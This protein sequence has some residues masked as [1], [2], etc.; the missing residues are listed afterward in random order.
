MIKALALSVLALAACHNAAAQKADDPCVDVFT[1]AKA[2]TSTY[3]PALV[4][5]R[6][7]HDYPAGIADAV[8]QDRD[9][10]IAQA[11]KEWETDSQPDHVAQACSSLPVSADDAEAAR[12][13]LAKS[14]CGEFTA[15][16]MPIFEKHF[17]K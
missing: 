2:C 8:K 14:D 11:M 3:I 4:D 7:R 9:G 1:R 16:F 17:T 13:C 10:V 5:A 12:T 6:A 15:C